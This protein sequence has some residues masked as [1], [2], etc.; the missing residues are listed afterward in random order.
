MGK[1]PFYQVTR[2]IPLFGHGEKSVF[3]IER[4]MRLEPSE[5]MAIR[6]HMGGLTTL[7]VAVVFQ[8]PGLSNATLL[9]LNCTSQIL[10]QPFW[11]KPEIRI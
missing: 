2:K 1:E 3:L 8:F 10:L 9:L 4:F 11:L 7:F 6:W 5:A